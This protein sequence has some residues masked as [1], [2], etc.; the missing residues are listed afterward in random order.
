MKKVIHLS[1][2]FFDDRSCVG[3]GERYPINVARG[4][5][6]H[7]G[8]R[9]TAEVL[10]FDTRASQQPIQPGVTIRL[11]RA[12]SRGDPLNVTSW[13]LPAA[14]ATADLVHIHQPAMRASELTLLIA[15]QFRKPVCVTDHGST[16]S[17]VGVF[18]DR[19]D[20]AD[21]IICYSDYGASLLKTRTPIHI[22]KGGIDSRYFIPP[23]GE[24]T[25]D[26]VLYVGRL[27]PYKSVDQLIEALP[28]ELGLTICGRPYD[29]AYFRL[30]KRLAAGKRV[31]FVANANDD[32]IRQFYQHALANVL[33]T[34]Y[35]SRY[36]HLQPAPE[37]MG[38]TLLEAQACGTP[39]LCNRA[40]AMPEFVRHGETG[41]IYDSQAELS[42]YLR[43]LAAD[44]KLVERLGQ[45]ARQ[46]AA[47]EF[48]YRVVAAKLIPIYDSLLAATASAA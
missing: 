46:I 33:P 13:E 28:P 47:Q 44:R 23:A 45:K 10:S 48:D 21:R 5:A 39:V 12:A 41:F 22:I 14:I 32:Q 37:L 35:E 3:G 6:E 20:L 34:R 25:R 4:I 18:P 2:L 38:L 26:R 9:H 17:T 30:L 31:R 8:G 1:P 40:G 36:G 15:K 24:P 19:L 11:L 43:Q 7:A 16:T 27:V 29:S 42:A